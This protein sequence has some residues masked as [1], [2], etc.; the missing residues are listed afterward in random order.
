[1]RLRFRSSRGATLILFAGSRKVDNSGDSSC[2]VRGGMSLVRALVV[3][4][5]D[6]RDGG[7]DVGAGSGE[8]R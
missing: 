6:G 4:F 8:F 5:G 3:A 1:M 7:G 2:T